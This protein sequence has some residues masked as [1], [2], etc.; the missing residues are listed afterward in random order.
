M[1]R[2]SPHRPGRPARLA[3]ALLAL[4]LSTGCIAARRPVVLDSTPP[5]AEVFIDGASSGHATPC[6]I[7][8]P[9]KA[10][11][12]EFRLEGYKT[13]VRQVVIGDRSTVVY[14]L[15]GFTNITTWPFPLFLSA[16]DFFF[17]IKVDDGEF[18]SRI[19][20]RFSRTRAARGPEAQ[21]AAFRTP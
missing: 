5:G 11:T 14:Y 3:A 21:E 16:K 9:N 17:P 20:I 1:A 8:L 10:R 7:Q 13:E 4:A 12:F 2:S 15:D 18:P 19:H 6:Q